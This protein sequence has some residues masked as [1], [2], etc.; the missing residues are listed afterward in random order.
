MNL[1]LDA[2]AQCRF[3][4]LLP[5]RHRGVVRPADFFAAA[6]LGTTLVLMT[7]AFLISP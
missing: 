1:R 3:N 2:L 4:D 6:F 5:H 7:S